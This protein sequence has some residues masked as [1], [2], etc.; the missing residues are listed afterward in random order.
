M[1]VLTPTQSRRNS[2]RGIVA[3]AV[4]AVTADTELRVTLVGDQAQVAPALDV[5]GAHFV[6]NRFR[7][8]EQ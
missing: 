3:G 7:L 2:N 5:R 6:R 1:Y 4:L 8:Q